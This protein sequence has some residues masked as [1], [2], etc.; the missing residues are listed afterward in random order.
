[1]DPERVGLFQQ[2]LP[3][4]V[5]VF[6]RYAHDPSFSP[7]TNPP[8]GSPKGASRAREIGARAQA[9]A[10]AHIPRFFGFS[11]P[12]EVHFPLSPPSSAGARRRTDEETPDRRDHTA[13][14]RRP[15]PGRPRAGIRPPGRARGSRAPPRRARGPVFPRVR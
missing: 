5:T 4:Q 11:G 13:A 15:R 7:K 6:F 14:A 2:L 12:F 10:R 1:R 3:G 9:V 8:A